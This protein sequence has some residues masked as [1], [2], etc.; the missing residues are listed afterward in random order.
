MI[1]LDKL[2]GIH[3]TALAL[4]GRRAEILAGNLA[5]ADT[6][7]YRARDLDFKAIL[8]G[9]SEDFLPLARTRGAH[10]PGSDEVAGGALQYRIPQQPSID[11]NTVDTQMEKSEFLRNAMQY[12]ASLRFL[13]GRISSLKLAISGQ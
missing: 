10:L 11:G 7:N 1:N 9:A 5:N 12:Q 6:P 8:S 2:F 3:A 4:H 13:N